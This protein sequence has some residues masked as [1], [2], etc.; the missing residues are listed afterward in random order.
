VFSTALRQRRA[1]T[2]AFRAGCQHDRLP[3]QALPSPKTFHIMLYL[4]H[5]Q[6][7]QN[8]EHPY[9]LEQ[10]NVV[11]GGLPDVSDAGSKV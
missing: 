11:G 9:T 3:D 6:D 7:I 1:G 5:I 2:D 10:L 8:P 4:Q